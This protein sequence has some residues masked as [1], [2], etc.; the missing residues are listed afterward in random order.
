MAGCGSSTSAGT[1]ASP[2]PAQTRVL[3]FSRTLGYRHASIP[4]GI[5]AI[6]ELGR[7]HGFSVDSTE[8]A[9]A[10]T[11]ANLS[12]YRVL[13]FLSSTGEVLE[14]SQRHALQ[15]FIHRGGGWVGIHAAADSLYDWP[16]YGS[17]LGTWFAS[18]PAIQP[19]RVRVDDPKDPATRGLPNPWNW[20]DEWYNFRSDPRQHVHVLLTL[21]E[22]SYEGGK[23]GSDH[24]LAWE[25][26]FDGGRAWYTG[27]GHQPATFA[28]PVFRSFL[29][30]GIGYAAGLA[31]L[32]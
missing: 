4:D 32:K 16:W 31:Y 21:D 7:E 6:E 10:F 30:A 28:S 14:G 19:A 25:H 17:L 12:R 9:A 1:T 27:L 18:H 29:L 22:T 15:G 24:P 26:E 3:V 2:R 13:V 20:T 23:M 8:D 5:A 11:P